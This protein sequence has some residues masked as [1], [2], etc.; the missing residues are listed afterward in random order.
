M[1]ENIVVGKGYTEVA[2]SFTEDQNEY[3]EEE[4]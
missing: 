4:S 3:S 1:P 2:V